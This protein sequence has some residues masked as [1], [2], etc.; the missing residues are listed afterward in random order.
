MVMLFVTISWE[1]PGRFFLTT[2]SVTLPFFK[3]P[4]YSASFHFTTATLQRHSLHRTLF[5]STSFKCHHGELPSPA[6]SA[7]LPLSAQHCFLLLPC[8]LVWSTF[9][10]TLHTPGVH[11]SEKENK[12]PFKCQDVHWV[13]WWERE[14]GVLRR[15]SGTGGQRQL[16]RNVACF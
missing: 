1:S 15:G 4:S 5:L 7:R 2:C 8:F 14:E 10:T 12:L 11:L 9:D 13:C 6:V 16:N 3:R